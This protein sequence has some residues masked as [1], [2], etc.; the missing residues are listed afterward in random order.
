M[1]AYINGV[2]TTLT[3]GTN[4]FNI[5]GFTVTANGVFEAANEGERVTFD[6][7]WMRIRS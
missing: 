3:S 2:K 1:E 4:T 7:R 5:D 6:K